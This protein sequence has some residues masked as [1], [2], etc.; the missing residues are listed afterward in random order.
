MLRPHTVAQICPLDVM[1]LDTIW[2][3]EVLHLR[4]T[5]CFTPIFHCKTLFSKTPYSRL[6]DGKMIITTSFSLSLLSPSSLF[7]LSS[8]LS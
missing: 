1:Q 5:E 4:S 7:T 3:E 8:S 6:G 2:V